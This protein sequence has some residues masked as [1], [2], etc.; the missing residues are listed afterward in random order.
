MR[1]LIR[2][3]KKIAFFLILVM[4]LGLV[5][6]RTA[7]ALT[8]GPSQPEMAA[9]EPI[10]NTD[11][12]DLF[13]GDFSYNIPLMDVGG[14]PVNLSYHSG[15]SM[16]DEASWVGYGWALNV[17]AVNRQLRGIP[18]DFNGTDKQERQ[19]NMKDHITKGAKFSMTLDLLGKPVP[20]LNIKKKKKK[21][22]L[23]LTVSIG[24][25]FDNYRGVGMEVGANPGLSLSEYASTPKAQGDSMVDL[26]GT[27]KLG[28][29]LNL[30]S[31]DGASVSVNA[32]TLKKTLESDDKE[33]SITKSVGFG[34][35]TRGGLTGLTLG[36]SYALTGDKK[37]KNGNFLDQIDFGHS[38][39]ISFNSPTYTPTIEHPM[40][41]GSFTFSL[42]LGPEVFIGFGGF[43][44]SGF[45]SKQSVAEKYTSAPEYGYIHSEKGR[46]I[47]DALMDMNREKDIPYSNQ[48]KYL[49]IPIPTYD[50]FSATSQDGSGQYRAYRGS[51]GVY[52]DKK[53]ESLNEDFSA[54]IE[55]GA[56]WFFDVG[57]DVYHQ[58]MATRSKKWI[59]RNEYLSKGDFQNKTQWEPLYDHAYFKRIGEPVPY[60]E[61][62][63]GKL[64]GTS[65]VAVEL[66]SRIDNVTDGAKA[67]G[68]LRTKS[69]PNGESI[70]TLKKTKRDVSNTT[71]SYLTASEA[72]LHGLEKDL[73]VYKPDSIPFGGCGTGAIKSSISRTSGY[74]KN[75]HISEITITGDDGK[76]S[77]YGIPVYNTYQEEVSFS[78]P[79]N[80]TLR[81]RGLTGYT[82]Q[83]NSI[84]NQ[85]GRERYYSKEI[86]PPYATSYLLTGIL[87]P[88][89]IDKTGN[90]ISDD[91]GG[92]AVK[93]NYTKLDSIYRWRTPF[94][95]GADTANYNE[96]F[97]TDLHDDKANYVYG[98]KEIWYLHSIESKT[99]VAH[100]ILENRDDGLGVSNNHGAV[101]STNKL[102]RLKEI[103]L[104]SKSDLR[105]N[106][107]NPAITVPIKVVHFVYDYSLCQGLPNSVGNTGKLTL[108][109]VYFTFGLNNKGRLN[110]YTF[111]YDTSFNYNYRQYDRW[112]NLKQASANPGGMNNSEFPYTLQDTLSNI[113][114][115]AWQLNKITLPS[116]GS[117]NVSYEADDY[118]WVQDK[119]ASV[120]C[121]LNGVGSQNSLTGLI[122]AN[123][124]YVR[125][126]YTPSSTADMLER[127]FE[128]V[129]TM[130]YKF[131]MDLD[132]KGHK[133]FVPGYA[134]LE[135]KPE[136]VPGTNIAKIKIRK[137]GDVNMIAKE[138][139]QFARTNLPK[140]AYPGSDNYGDDGSDLVKAI[141]ALITAFGNI[142]ELIGGFERRAKNKGYSN[143]V[144][145]L[146]SFVRLCAPTWKK[147][148]G[149]SRVKRIEVY[150]DWANMS[151]TTGAKSATYTQLYDYTTGSKYGPIS[152]GVAS[153]EPMLGNDENPFRQPLRYQ[154]SQFLALNN[155]YYIEEPF[156]E[157]LFP[158]ANVGYSK[159]TVRSIGSGDATTVNRTG[160]VVSEFFTARD[161]P[162]KLDN[163]VLEKRKPI[164]SYIFKLIGSVVY[165]MVG[166]SQGFSIE[167]ND[168]HGKPK[169]T[170]VYNK[171][172]QNISSVEYFY[173]TRN[174][175]ATTKELD[176]TV[177]M[178]DATGTVTDGTIGM[179]VEMYTDM[180]Q[181]T[182]ENLGESVKVSGGLGAILIFPLPFFFPGVDVNYEH[183]SYRAASSVKIINRFAIQYK[184]KKMENGSSITSE[185]LLW[186]AETGNVLL[187]RTQN[188]FDD[189]VYSFAYPAHWVYDRMGQAYRNLGT[190]LAG[191]TTASNGTISNST[192]NSLL[193]PGDELIDLNAEKRYWIINSPVSGSTQKRLIDS[194]GNI[195]QVTLRTMK[196]VRSGRRNMANTAIATIVSLNNP[197]VG[198]KL[199]VTQ[200][201]KVLDAKATVFN[202]EWS[203]PVPSEEGEVPGGECN[204]INDACI[205]KFILAAM[206]YMSSIG[207]SPILSEEPVT[208]REVIN[209]IWP[210]TSC[211]HELYN[212]EEPANMLFYQK[213]VTGTY[214][215]ASISSGDTAQFGKCIIIFDS[216]KSGFNPAANSW[217]DST[218]FYGE[219]HGAS[220]GFCEFGIVDKGGTKLLQYH[221]ECTH[222]DCLDPVSQKINPYLTGILGNWRAQSQFA[223]HVARQNLVTDPGKFGSTD[224]RKSGAYSVFN[225]F[226]KYNSG[227]DQNPANDARWIAANQVTYFNNKG[228][229]IENK[230]ALNRYSSAIFGYLESMPIAV[231]SNSQYREIGYEGFEDYGFSLLCPGKVDTCN[232]AGPFSFRRLLNGSTVD[233]TKSFAHSGKY[234]LKVNNTSVTLGKT[235][236][237]GVPD[238]FYSF[239]STGSYILEANELSKGFS[240]I[241]GKKYVLSFWVKDGTPRNPTTSVQAT[242]NG[243]NLISGSVPWPI[244]EGWKH[245]EVPF[246]LSGMASSFTLQLAS[247]SGT[248]YFDDIRIHPFN[249]QMK[250]FAY[251]A[252]TQRLMAELDENNFA[253]F[254]EYDD[255]GILVRVKKETERGIMTIKETR[256]SYKKQ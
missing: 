133:E 18:D 207:S 229:E 61:T 188:E 208:V 10:G 13:S 108:K 167:L 52:F 256:S 27:D 50:L 156:C 46:D 69:S 244:A 226:W 123:Y 172:G 195:K 86:T 48:V 223:Y 213:H 9:F 190:M 82:S 193:V 206:C 24:I 78:T 160:S 203:V 189:P 137:R 89:Y 143:T 7:F 4:A 237:T 163:L 118:A 124:I 97:I 37:G 158:A 45:F 94:A 113:Y 211:S 80:Q 174:E 147:T 127:F 191:F 142:K 117:I 43:G 255:E 125:L 182:M 131:Y 145:T 192:Y 146:K 198:N 65:P 22:N 100:F 169:S 175:L 25:K 214:P 136:L 87:S 252:S 122:N 23:S 217:D 246:T 15:A 115:R 150:D 148:G 83:D 72:A 39:F 181:H 239:N 240:P 130:Y 105:L 245:I 53:T 92:T 101:N 12:V 99:M 68:L 247:G 179:D 54:G 26:I 165:E 201:T 235:V 20:R 81:N 149:G 171:S 91:D 196:L 180:R 102:R 67:S 14:Y 135:E 121:M 238:S 126:P 200:L 221:V 227:W 79:T 32:Q 228:V 215:S 19:M 186:D 205:A 194:T 77:I 212:G 1:Y 112:G 216:V 154:Q 144:D 98:E 176:N 21:L 111:Q 204:N 116:G 132:G 243:S 8:S 232:D 134:D 3:Q 222:K 128:N 197:I 44:G 59:D 119:R 33:Q 114:A 6:P 161:Y 51:S 225:P 155:Y 35:N 251:D 210:D 234:S 129:T 57:A 29:G 96:G 41:T 178:I 183:R 230:D 85:N 74:R 70:S 56:G 40:K 30:S 103:R 166:L 49:P 164:S 248:V 88:D 168:M 71:F 110:P 16:D 242:V 250:T 84:D 31:M 157:S 159:V 93:F 5:N 75:H 107:N 220:Y 58:S 38:S 47:P 28:I 120:M 224:I 219:Y 241:P 184:V 218:D 140:W 64:K 254:Y 199:N 76:R 139:W 104:Y 42:H 141:K 90:G 162:V 62:Y 55:L 106:G 2:H 95:Y 36:G 151:G 152:T 66:P 138:G 231:A 153:Y 249:G 63:I 253:T 202:E 236:F 185:N 60:D 17:G 34:Y 73:I 233:T 187:T 209:N 109:K 170:K 173:K 177:K 11:M